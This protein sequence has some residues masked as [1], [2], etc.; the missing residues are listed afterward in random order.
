M[1]ILEKLTRRWARSK[2]EERLEVGRPSDPE[3]CVFLLW[4]A[5]I[6]HVVYKDEDG[7]RR[8]VVA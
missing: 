5:T 4:P 3:V 2:A 1:K 6:A 8:H 7:Q